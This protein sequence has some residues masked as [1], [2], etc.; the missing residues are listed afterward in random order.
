MNRKYNP[1]LSLVALVLLALIL[2]LSCTGCAVEAAAATEPTAEP[3]AGIFSTSR[4]DI[5]HEFSVWPYLEEVY[6]ITD[7]ETGVQ[8]LFVEG[9]QGAAGLCKLEGQPW[10]D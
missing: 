4:F 10:K 9:A 2:V 1:M 8:Y 7:N 5:E 6:V 3:E